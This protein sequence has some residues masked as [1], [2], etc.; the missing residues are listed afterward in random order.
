V[1]DKSES[2]SKLEG[3]S[4]TWIGTRAGFIDSAELNPSSSP[5]SVVAIIPLAGVPEGGV[6]KGSP[7]PYHTTL[8]RFLTH[9]TT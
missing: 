9:I 3:F 4:E 5:T 6:I 1:L 2:K 7:Q 8:K